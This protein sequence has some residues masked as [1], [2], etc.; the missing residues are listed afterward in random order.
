MVTIV[1]D[2]TV[3]RQSQRGY[4]N[5]M[6]EESIDLLRQEKTKD[7]ILYFATWKKGA[8]ESGDLHGWCMERSSEE[9]TAGIKDLVSNQMLLRVETPQ[10]NYSVVT[11][12]VAHVAR[13][14]PGVVK[15]RL[16][17]EE[18]RLT[19][20][21]FD[22]IVVRHLDGCPCGA[23]RQQLQVLMGEVELRDLSAS[24]SRLEELKR[25]TSARRHGATVYELSSFV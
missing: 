17:L 1:I 5:A 24:L 7:D 12:E 16:H 15:A 23:T 22:R 13:N 11:F 2:A 20:E 14:A 10:G 25:V 4:T 21:R 18:T 19:N 8:A 9:V 6:S 3:A